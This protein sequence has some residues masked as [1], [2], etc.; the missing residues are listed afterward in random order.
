MLALPVLTAKAGFFLSFLCI[1][2]C[3]A[4]MTYTGLLLAE[5]TL[6]VKNETHF[7][8]LS[9]ILVGNGTR[10]VAL[11]VYMFMNY[12]SLVAYTAGGAQLF[13]SQAE[14]HFGMALS[15]E[16]ACVL[17]TVAFGS[18]IY[19]GARLVGNINFAFVI[20]LVISYIA[21]V[22]LG[23]GHVEMSN[24]TREAQ[25]GESLG[26]LSIILAAFS[27]QMIVPSLCL[28]MNYDMA[29]L[30][31]AIILGTT[32]PFVVYSLLLFVIHGVVPLE[33]ESGLLAALDRGASATE[34]LRAQFNH[35]SLTAISDFFAFFAIITS[36][37]GLS[38]AL[39]YFLKDCFNEI[40]ITLSKN[41]I[42]LASIIP[43]MIMAILFPKALTQCLDISGGYGDTILSGLIPVAMVWMGR[44]KL[45]KEATNRIPGGKPALYIV[46]AFFGGIF[47]LQII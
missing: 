40:K 47:L 5:A 43:T 42:I 24:L 46:A 34:P 37:I 9:R 13:M 22:G 29:K 36:Y 7:S 10:L 6:W 45:G 21:L 12:A 11:L 16:A 44:Y 8:S 27:Y 28:Q 35:W 39:F 3:W 32:L 14:L 19:L 25:I 2:V 26:I 31:K 18:L 23:I 17:F 1:A 4:F 41:Q 30:K 33:G 38:L 20:G 15:Y